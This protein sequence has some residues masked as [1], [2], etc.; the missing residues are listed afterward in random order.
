MKTPSYKLTEKQADAITR[1][2]QNTD[3]STVLGLVAEQNE[4]KLQMLVLAPGGNEP[5]RGQVQAL[6][7][8]LETIIDAPI[9]LEALSQRKDP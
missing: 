5:L 1:L 7:E 9:Q 3:F 6:T 4:R 8:F 2:R